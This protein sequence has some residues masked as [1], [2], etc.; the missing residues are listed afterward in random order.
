MVS[1]KKSSLILSGTIALC[2]SIGIES[3]ILLFT[4][5]MMYSQGGEQ[6]VKQTVPNFFRILLLWSCVFASS[7]IKTLLDTLKSTYVNI[8][9][10]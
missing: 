6:V 3:V 5:N 7:R 10:R 1:N 4:D 9:V 8:P 2:I